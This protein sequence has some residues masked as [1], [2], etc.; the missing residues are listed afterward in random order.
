[1]FFFCFLSVAGDIENEGKETYEIV[2]EA[3]DMG[4]PPFTT[5]TTV[6]VTVRDTINSPPK[7]TVSNL[8]GKFNSELSRLFFKH[9]TPERINHTFS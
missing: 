2:V 5:T 9:H 3:S 7:M 1:M 4:S 6:I 8:Y